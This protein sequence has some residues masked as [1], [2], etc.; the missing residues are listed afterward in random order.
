ME[1]DYGNADR[2]G[3]DAWIGAVFFHLYGKNMHHPSGKGSFVRAERSF[4]NV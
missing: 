2:L 4:S 3:D 1:Y